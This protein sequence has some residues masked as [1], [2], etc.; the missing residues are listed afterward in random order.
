MTPEEEGP[1]EM[2]LLDRL[3]DDDPASLR[4]PHKSRPQA[5][6]EMLDAVRRDLEAMLNTRPC[7]VVLDAGLAGLADSI[8]NYGVASVGGTV[9]GLEENR[10]AFRDQ[11]EAAIRRFEPRLMRVKVELVPDPEGIDRTIRFR[12]VAELNARP[13]PEPL[14]FDSVLDPSTLGISVQAPRNV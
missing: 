8:L 2:S 9:Y 7:S 11:I 6:R 14:V 1:F 12:V 13:A 3:L 5:H 4:D 10:A